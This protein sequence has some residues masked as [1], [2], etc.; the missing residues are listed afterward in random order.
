MTEEEIYHTLHVRLDGSPEHFAAFMIDWCRQT[1]RIMWIVPRITLNEDGSVAMV[2]G[3]QASEPVIMTHTFDDA[4]ERLNGKP[5]TEF[6]LQP[7]I[8][9]IHRK[10]GTVDGRYRT[11]SQYHMP[12]KDLTTSICGAAMAGENG[13]Q[14][15]FKKTKV[16]RSLLCTHCAR[17]T[18]IK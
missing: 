16:L 12:D 17:G 2:E 10:K 9:Y 18:R 14:L 8:R 4:F 13:Y 11:V 6:D 7:G 5:P 1:Y 3:I 15:V